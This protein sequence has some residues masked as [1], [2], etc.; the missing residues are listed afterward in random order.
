MSDWFFIV[1]SRAP[2][3][4][5]QFDTVS[6]CFYSSQDRHDKKL[7]LL[8]KGG[9][10]I[11]AVCS[12]KYFS[13]TNLFNLQFYLFFHVRNTCLCM[14]KSLYFTN[15]DIYSHVWKILAVDTRYWALNLTG[16]S[17]IISNQ[18]R[19][20]YCSGKTSITE[21]YTLAKN[22]FAT[23]VVLQAINCPDT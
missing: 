10:V 21:L 8:M 9:G 5:N 19:L 20:F 11:I 13:M 23:G 14:S 17:N 15:V 12:E 18:S 4:Y 3:S 16:K 6:V 2:V 1:S 7:H 22:M